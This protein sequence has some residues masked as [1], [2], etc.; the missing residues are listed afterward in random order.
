[1]WK[2]L[3]LKS[4]ESCTLNDLLL[5][6]EL[7]GSYIS[8]LSIALKLFQMT[9]RVNGL[10]YFRYMLY[11]W[12]CLHFSDNMTRSYIQVYIQ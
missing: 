1:M 11:G 4:N 12:L 2:V 3:L 6:E 7:Y 8:P 9:S 5:K 10:M